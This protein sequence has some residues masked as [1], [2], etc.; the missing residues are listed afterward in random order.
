MK[1]NLVLMEDY[2]SSLLWVYDENNILLYN[3]VPDEWENDT[4]L[5]D[6]LDKAEMLYK[7]CFVNDGHAFKYV[8]FNDNFFRNSYLEILRSL[9]KYIIEKLPKD[10]SLVDKIDYD[11]YQSSRIFW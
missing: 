4:T 10:W 7:S 3:G 1:M 11:Q 6:Y 5:N 9:K 8:G 2:G